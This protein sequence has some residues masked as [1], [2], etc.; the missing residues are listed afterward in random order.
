MIYYF[1]FGSNMNIERLE[2]ARLKPEG[3]SVEAVI[4]GRLDDF[5]VCFDKTAPH[6]IL[7]G[8]TNIQES[9]GDCVYGTLNWVDERALTV[10]DH[11]ESVAENLYQRVQVR[12]QRSDG[13]WV[14]AVAYQAQPPF[15][16][17]ALPNREYLSHLLA[18]EAY[19]PKDYF[20]RLRNWPT[21]D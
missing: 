9:P 11:Y 8:V 5:R 7:G 14:D 16:Q 19:L 12:C 6:L 10:L 3:L 15:D 17:D 13:A 18:G 4:G 2:T 20:S 21:V 1:A